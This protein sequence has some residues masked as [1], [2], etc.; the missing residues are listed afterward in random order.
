MAA[1]LHDTDMHICV[2]HDRPARV[3]ELHL[4]VVHCLCEAVDLQLLGDH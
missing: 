4:L 3:H 2:P 1:A